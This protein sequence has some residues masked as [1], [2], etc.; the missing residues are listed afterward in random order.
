MNF[1][2]LEENVKRKDIEHVVPSG[3]LGNNDVST[4]GRSWKYYFWDSWDKSPEVMITGPQ[5]GGSC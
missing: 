1:G 5:P 2:G 4:E 3:V